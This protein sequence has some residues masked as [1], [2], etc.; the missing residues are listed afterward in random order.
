M[1][2]WRIGRLPDSPPA[3]PSEFA[4]VR[5]VLLYEQNPS[6]LRLWTEYAHRVGIP[7][8]AAVNDDASRRRAVEQRVEEWYDR[9]ASPDEIASPIRSALA[10][11]VASTPGATD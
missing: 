10:R 11:G 4:G 6:A 5:M 9:E 8:V 7:V 1:D 2:G 3:D